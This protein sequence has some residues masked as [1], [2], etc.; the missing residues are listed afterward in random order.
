MEIVVTHS[1]MDFDAL[2]SQFAVSKLYPAA[3]IVLGQPLTGNVRRFLSLYRSS[4]PIVQ[5]KYIDLSKVTHV[6]VVDCQHSGRL[7]AAV[8]KLI[9]AEGNIPCTVFDH[10]E[11]DLDSASL[12]SKAEAD[13]IIEKVGACTT[14]LVDKLRR[15]KTTLSPFEATLLAIGIYEDTGGLIY[16]G[17]TEKD[18]LCVSYLLKNGADLSIVDEHIHPR[19]TDEQ[20][21]LFETLLDNTRRL[22]I[23]GTRILICHA[24]LPKYLDGLA[25]LTR[26]LV[27]IESAHVALTAVHMRDR[28]HIVARSDSRSLD[29]RNI[30]RAFGGD[31]H[32]GAAS[33]VVHDSALDS[34]CQRLEEL[35]WQWTRTEVTAIEIMTT[36]TRTV[37]P[38]I[39]MDE[40]SRI[41]IRYGVDGL[42]VTE[43]NK[44]EGVVSRRDIDQA[45]HHKLGHAPVSGFM[46]RPVL[47]IAP[48]TPLSKIQEIMVKEDVGRLPV[49]DKEGNLLGLVSRPDVLKTVYG[50]RMAQE[51]NAVFLGNGNG[52]APVSSAPISI[53]VQDKLLTLDEEIVWLC[54]NIGLSAARSNMTAYIVGGFLRDLLLGLPNFDLDIVV[55][56]SANELAKALQADYSTKFEICAVHDRFQTAHLYFLGKEKRE[57][58]FSTART[59]FYEYPAALPTVEASKLEQ[60]L[61]RRDFTINSLAACINPDRFG[62]VIDLFGGVNDIRNKKIR[63]LH[64]F[65]FIEDPTR[66][67]RAARFAA[68]LGFDLDAK[69]KE[70]AKRAIA[71]GIFDNLGGVRMRAELQ[72]ILESKHRLKALNLLAGLGGKIRY[73]DAELEFDQQIEKMIRTAERLL[74]RYKVEENWIVYLGVLLARLPATR[75]PA[76]LDRLHLSND[77]KEIIKKGLQISLQFPE[78]FHSVDWLHYQNPKNSQIYELLSDKAP[79]SLAIAGSAASAGSPMRRLIRIYLQK[80]KNVHLEINGETLKQIGVPEGPEIG[81]ILKAILEAKLDGLAL[82]RDDEIKWAQRLAGENRTE[83]VGG[84]G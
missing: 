70:Q 59:E 20:I 25:T 84:L 28:I 78:L 2:A 8:R 76:V 46:S 63:I 15:A 10:H 52:C 39:A 30:V 74:L 72:M 45:T 60:D 14:I 19:L 21:E 36:P 83:S 69:T 58:D 55:E 79:E 65:S 9:S 57:I 5:I 11:K 64:A 33:A 44:I 56:G 50:G 77:Q 80:L 43:N 73:L 4:L 81:R 23:N 17:T 48:E 6:Y 31:G 68:R 47:T 67:V 53:N 38:D 12:A 71:M 13:S 54:Q 66:I 16:G 3:K 41:M 22:D 1:N 29:V 34:V 32:A 82:T 35:A 24:Q 61:S 49:L 40:A 42:L 7:D 75:L 26:K 51:P 62:E 18:A 27:E 37:R